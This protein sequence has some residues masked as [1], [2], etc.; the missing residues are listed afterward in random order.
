MWRRNVG[1]NNNRISVRLPEAE[2][3]EVVKVAE[4][5]GV[6]ES[7]VVRSAIRRFLAGTKK[8]R[9]TDMFFEE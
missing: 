5:F 4:K 9:R 7:V 6:P 8:T 1:K 2:H 3:K